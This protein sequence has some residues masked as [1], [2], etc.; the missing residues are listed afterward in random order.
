MQIDHIHMVLVIPPKY[1]VS[2]I[3]GKMKANV[4][5]HLRLRY[6][7][8]KRTYWGGGVVV[9]GVFLFDGGVE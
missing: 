7:A 2:S 8:L 5:R 6:S 4:S 3:V 9:A 1:A